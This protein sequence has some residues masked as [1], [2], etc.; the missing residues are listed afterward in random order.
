M[1]L[2][3]LL[4]SLSL[5]VAN[6]T[7]ADEPIKKSQVIKNGTYKGFGILVKVK[8]ECVTVDDKPAAIIESNQSATVYQS[9]LLNVIFYKSGCIVLIK[10]GVFVG[11]LKN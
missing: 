2:I 10:D 7:L 1:K 9:G 4:M 3:I 6:V 8:K 5:S 11:Y